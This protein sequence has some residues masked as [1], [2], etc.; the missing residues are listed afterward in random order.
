MARSRKGELDG[1]SIDEGILKREVSE[2]DSMGNAVGFLFGGK[3][4][5]K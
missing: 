4:Y 5:P 2:R 1:G 3:L